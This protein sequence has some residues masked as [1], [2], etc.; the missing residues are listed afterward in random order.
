MMTPITHNVI[1]QR[2]TACSFGVV[3]PVVAG[4]VESAGLTRVV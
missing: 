1:A 3:V 4:P 2:R